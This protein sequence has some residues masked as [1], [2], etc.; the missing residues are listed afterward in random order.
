[1][2]ICVILGVMNY[3]IKQVSIIIPAYNEEAGIKSTLTELIE[4]MS[5]LEYTYEIILVD[6]GSKDNT[7]II[8]REME[9]NY[10]DILRV[11]QHTCNKGYGSS[12]KTAVRIAEGDYIA[13]YDA[14]GQHRP[15]D[16]EK[17]ICCIF[18]ENLDYCIGNRTKDSYEEKT[19]K[20][21]KTVLKFVV[22]LLAKEKM[23]DFN[24]G[25]RIFKHEIIKKHANLLPKRFGA[26]TVT[27][28]LMQELEYGGGTC[29]IIVRQRVGKSSVRQIRDGIR[30]ILL[31]FQIIL[32][33]RP[34]QVFGSI[35][36]ISLIGG[37]IYGLQTAIIESNG[38]PVL[39]AIIMIFG[40]QTLFFGLIV[41]QI[42]RLRIEV[43]ELRWEK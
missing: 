39:G 21:G 25:M 19:R 3:M 34:M 2:K 30:T 5:S 1:M 7:Y 26:S 36:V 41:G 11:E 37:G 18:H 9:Q 12:I 6:D 14:D 43:A 15:E 24:S 33:F 20:L 42:S 16:L 40:I 28:F 31:I 8:A 32:L 29:P 4:Y 10:P 22:N 13:W 38:F 23:E 17:L 27:S 35:G